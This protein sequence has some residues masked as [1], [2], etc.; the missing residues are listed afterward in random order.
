MKRLLKFNVLITCTLCFVFSDLLAQNLSH[1]IVDAHCHIKTSPDEGSF[2]TMDEYFAD[3][4][5][6][7]VK[8]LFG[9]TMA[10]KGNIERMKV[11]NDSLFSMSKRE[12]RFIPVCSVHPSDTEAAIEELHRIKGLGGKIIKLHP[13]TQNFPVL[14]EE[15]LLVVR[16]AG[17]LGLVI[18]IDGMGNLDQLLE[19]A[20]VCSNTKIIIAHMG[21]SEFHKL[22]GF[23]LF[24]KS[25][26]DAFKN[27]WFDISVTVYLYAGSPYQS[28]LEWIIKTVG[29]DR[30]LFGSDQPAVS[31][32]DALNAFDKLEFN[33]SERE[34]IL[35]RNAIELLELPSNR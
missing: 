34:K 5:S 9:I 22:A 13:M 20:I 3:N 26:P 33:D 2:Q 17:E 10:S 15:T 25:M 28:Q 31:L 32:S 4:E 7:N 14:G 27:L 16:T 11:K 8:Y 18:L 1:P 19:L 30:V 12:A 35:F 23:N 6:V 21:V 29:V 24:K